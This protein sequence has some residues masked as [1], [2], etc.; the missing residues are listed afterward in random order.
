MTLS[1]HTRLL[2]LGVAVAGT[3]FGAGFAVSDYRHTQTFEDY[4]QIQEIEAEMQK[5]FAE[6]RK[7][8]AAHM[9]AERARDALSGEHSRITAAQKKEYIEL[10]AEELE[11]ERR[12][13]LQDVRKYMEEVP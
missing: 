6:Y 3:M 2:L 11:A 9:E 4:R 10:R 8:S 1:L 5:D 7:A 13:A 12:A